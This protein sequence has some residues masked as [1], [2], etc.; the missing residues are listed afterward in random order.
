MSTIGNIAKIDA[1]ERRAQNRPCGLEKDAMKAVSG[2]AFVPLRLR[3]QNDSFHARMILNR[4]AEAMP[5]AAR[6]IKTLTISLRKDAPSIR[7]ASRISRGTSRK[8]ECIIHIIIGR[9]V[10]ANMSS[11]PIRLSSSPRFRYIRKIGISTPTGGNI[12]VDNI[13]NSMPRLLLEGMNAKAQA[14]GSA[15]TIA[16]KVAPPDSITELSA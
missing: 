7:A 5:G 4:A 9:F 11:N 14:A 12:F 6:G 1:A 8:Y 13:Q 16:K 10:A 15:S 2:A 3:D